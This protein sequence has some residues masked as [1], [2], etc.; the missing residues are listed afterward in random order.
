MRLIYASA[1]YSGKER[2]AADD[3]DE[4]HHDLFFFFLSLLVWL[5]S[6]IVIRWIDCAYVEYART[7]MEKCLWGIF[8]SR[9]VGRSEKGMGGSDLS[10]L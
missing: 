3:Y 4:Q 10:P 6:V 2:P 7:A 5:V 1:H 8:C 9:S